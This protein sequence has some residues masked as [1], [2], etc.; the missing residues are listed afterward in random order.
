MDIKKKSKITS[1]VVIIAFVAVIV[2]LNVFVTML[3]KKIPLKIDMT[4]NKLYEV[5][6]KTK[7]FLSSYST[8]TDIYIMAGE[9]SGDENVRAVLDKYAALN[10]NIKIKNINPAQNPTFGQNY[11]KDGESLTANSVIIDTGKRFKKYRLEELYSVNSQTGSVAGINVEN[12]ITSALRYVSS[13][14]ELSVCFLTGHGESDFKGAKAQLENDNYTVKTVNLLNEEIPDGVSSVICALPAS[15]FTQAE[16]AKLDK[17]LEKGG[18]VQFY[19]DVKSNKLTNLYS[20]LKQWGIQPEDKVIIEQNDA[21]KL[22]LS[23]GGMFLLTPD[24]YDSEITSDI[25]EKNRILAYY[26]YAKAVTKL[27]DELNGIKVTPLMGSTKNAYTTSNYDDITKTESDETGEFTFALL[28]QNVSTGASVYVSGTAMLYTIEPEQITNGYGFAN[29]GYFTNLLN[30]TAGNDESMT[31]EEKSLISDTMN[32]SSAAGF[33]I[34][35]I[36]AIAIPAVII[37]MGIIR[38]HKRRNL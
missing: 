37:I 25:K 12:K 34:G 35:I 14:K 26:P 27:F 38:W 20:Y 1:S 29:Y 4:S 17:Y 6:D 24:I 19:F 28:S 30:Y 8:P 9:A 5:S 10:K 33:L 32:I 22:N 31:V 7:E 16:A 18:S 13:Q 23:T 21:N 2:L 3:N 36:L 11:V 15:D